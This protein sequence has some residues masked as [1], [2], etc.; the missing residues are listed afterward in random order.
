MNDSPRPLA[1]E[2][3]GVR[4]K[5]MS[6]L[7]DSFDDPLAAALEIGDRP[8]VAD[9]RLRAAVLAQTV[10]VLRGRRRLKRCTL[11]A[12][13]LA[14]YLGGVATMGLFSAGRE[15]GHPQTPG[16]TLADNPK[17]AAPHRRHVST[18]PQEE[19]LTAK[20]PSRFE[21]WRR[22]GD[23]F[24]RDS[25]DVSLAV[26]GYSEAIHLASA[27]ERR[28]SPEQDNWLLMALKQDAQTRERKHVTEQN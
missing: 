20:K 3:P 4:A 18:H 14:C 2:G 12:G 6:E 13:L 16:P 5:S 26:A 19:K 28:I 23:H 21:S 24:L 8:H 17:D 7:N 11:A 9:D 10:G 15:N 27:E 25:G 1:G 22:I